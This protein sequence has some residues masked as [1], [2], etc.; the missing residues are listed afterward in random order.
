LAKNNEGYKELNDFLSHHS[1]HKIDFSEHAPQFKNALIIY[2]FRQVL[3]LKKTDFSSNEYIGISIKEIPKLRFSKLREL[4]DQLVILQPVTF[5]TKKDFNTHRLLRAIDNN[6]LLSRLPIEQQAC[7]SEQMK[8]NDIIRNQFAEFNFIIKNTENII[9]ECVISFDFSKNK[10]SL[11]QKTYTGSIEQDTILL[12][13]LCKKGLPER[14]NNPDKKV[15]DRIKKELSLIIKMNFVS[16]FL[17]NWRIIS[18]AHK[19]GYYYVGRGS[20]ANSIVAYL[21]RITDVDPIDLDLYFERFINSHRTS[22]PDFDIDFSWRDRHD[23]TQFIFK[24]FNHVAL[25]GTYVTFHYK[26]AVREK[27]FLQYNL[28]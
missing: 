7:F 17:I 22:P 20:G 26:G 15:Q 6:I 24:E 5:R 8:P 25:L 11:N 10:P 18:Y 27:A 14:Y 21:L 4:K 16:Y 3:L 12:K 13:K 28:I 23:I 19:K 1:H 9:N 2:P